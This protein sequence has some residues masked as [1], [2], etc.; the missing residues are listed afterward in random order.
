MKKILFAATAALLM[1]VGTKANAQLYFGGSVA[2]STTTW[3]DGQNQANS[4]T[5]GFS[6]KVMPEVGFRFNDRMAVG[7]TIG[8]MH[9]LAALGSLN[10]NDYK[11][12]LLA[13]AGMQGD[14]LSAVNAQGT[15]AN[16]ATK[17][18]GIRIAPYF[19]FS[20]VS[21]RRFDL[22]ADAVVGYT[23]VSTQSLNAANAWVPG[24][25]IGMLEIGIRPGFLV[26][27]DGHFSIMA[28]IG[29]FGYQN[30]ATTTTNPANNAK[31]TATIGRFGLDVDSYNIMLGF[32]YSL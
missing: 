17:V 7:G 2:F 6:F 24:P 15:F 8:Y 12:V 10:P 23:S 22:F 26:K 21:T 1:L 31:T 32:I 20:F 4:K 29:S 27:F 28:H 19:R 9:G 13:Y 18:G 25:N 30:I 5:S 16:G 11:G 3:N 14:G